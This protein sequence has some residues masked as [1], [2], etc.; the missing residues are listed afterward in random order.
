MD[1]VQAPLLDVL[2]ARDQS[3]DAEHVRRAALEEVRELLGLRLAGRVAAGAALAP[4]SQ[5]GP[6]ADVQGPGPGRAEERL[7]ARKSE[8]VDLHRLDID[9]NDAGGLGGVDE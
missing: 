9:L 1:R 3:G 7:V 4:G 6:R 2:D 8:Q 5:L